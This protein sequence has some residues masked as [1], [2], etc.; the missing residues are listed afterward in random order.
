MMAHLHGRRGTVLI[1]SAGRPRN[2]LVQV[3]ESRYVVP[4]GNLFSLKSST[5]GGDEGSRRA[6]PSLTTT[7]ATAPEAAVLDR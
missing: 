1:R 7:P 6:S 5:A 4:C 2:H 3:D